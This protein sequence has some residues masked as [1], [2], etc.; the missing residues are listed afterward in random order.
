MKFLVILWFLIPLHAYGCEVSSKFES[1][2]GEIKIY[3]HPPAANHLGSCTFT[4][5]EISAH[6]N[7]NLKFTNQ[8]NYRVVS[9]Y[10]R[11]FDWYVKDLELYMEKESISKDI[12]WPQRNGV[13]NDYF[14]LP[15]TKAKLSQTLSNRSSYISIHCEKV[16]KKFNHF[17]VN[18]ACWVQ[19]E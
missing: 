4:N 19:Y 15:E 5:M 8:T 13:L 7:N 1:D 10:P 14:S 17:Y 3:L 9:F 12:P 11:I 18:G 2:Q 16:G 6:I